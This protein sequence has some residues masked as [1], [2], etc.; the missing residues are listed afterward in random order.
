MTPNGTIVVRTRKWLVVSQRWELKPDRREPCRKTAM[1]YAVICGSAVD[2]YKADG[3]PVARRS[4]LL[5]WKHEVLPDTFE[6]NE[7][8]P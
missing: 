2:W 7:E 5:R 6:S 4:G 1:R 3:Q 8:L